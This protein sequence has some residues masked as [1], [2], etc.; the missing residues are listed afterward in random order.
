MRRENW[1]WRRSPRPSG[2]SGIWIAWSSTRTAAAVDASND[3]GGASWF[4]TFGRLL[5]R[6]DHEG[7]PHHVLPHER[8]HVVPER[9][10][11]AAGFRRER[12]DCVADGR[13]AAQDVEQLRG[14]RLEPPVGGEARRRKAERITGYAL[15]VAQ[16]HFDDES[17][18]GRGADLRPLDG[19]LPAGEYVDAL[20]VTSQRLPCPRQPG[21]A[22]QR[23][24]RLPRL[25]RRPAQVCD[26]RR[27]FVA[28]AVEVVAVA[29]RGL[30]ELVA[31]V[32]IVHERRAHGPRVRIL[33][34][35]ADEDE[36]ASAR[37]ADRV[38]SITDVLGRT[39]GV[40]LDERLPARRQYVGHAFEHD[41][42]QLVAALAAVHEHHRLDVV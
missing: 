17:A 30:V 31:E 3:G 42:R 10:G 25:I 11:L 35:A 9:F 36:I 7:A 8:Q 1:P 22:E 5:L 14:A 21:A 40:E 23:R 19:A 13:R 34:R 33:D 16:R 20:D 24:P 41:V 29:N 28:D 18:A 27:P 4:V 38:H 32:G 12:R 15:A 39:R 6:F 2:A 26:R 37:A